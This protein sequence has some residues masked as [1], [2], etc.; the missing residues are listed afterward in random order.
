[1]KRNV[2]FFIKDFSSFRELVIERPY[3]HDEKSQMHL[4]R[5]SPSQK[6]DEGVPIS[7]PYRHYICTVSAPYRHVGKESS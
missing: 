7:A 2:F 3:R 6:N 5:V 1:M 4:L